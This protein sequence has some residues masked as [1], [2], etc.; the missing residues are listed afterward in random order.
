MECLLWK[1]KEFEQYVCHLQ[2]VKNNYRK[3]EVLTQV[4]GHLP[5]KFET[6]RS[7]PSNATQKKKK[8]IYRKYEIDLERQYIFILLG[9]EFRFRKE[10]IQILFLP[11]K[12]YIYHFVQCT[13]Y[14]P[15]SFSHLQNEE[16]YKSDYLY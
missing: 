4:V 5:K 15:V 9:M 12:A 2:R 16:N 13:K 1:T 8:N 10:W 7:S 3:T 14:F 11:C 6:L